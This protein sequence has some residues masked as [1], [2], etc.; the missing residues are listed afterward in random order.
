[1]DLIFASAL[2][3]PSAAVGFSSK[4]SH[5]LSVG[6]SVPVFACAFAATCLVLRNSDATM[7][8]SSLSEVD[9]GGSVGINQVAG[10]RLYIHRRPPIP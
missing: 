1:M 3:M 6:S 10:R 9:V 2:V 4:P 7:V 5:A 8:V